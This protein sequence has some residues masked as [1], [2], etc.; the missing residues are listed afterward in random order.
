MGF[1]HSPSTELG[2]AKCSPD[3]AQMLALCY[4]VFLSDFDR[5]YTESVLKMRLDAQGKTLPAKKALLLPHGVDLRRQ[6]P[7]VQVQHLPRC[8]RVSLF[9]LMY[10]RLNSIDV[11]FRR[12]LSRS[13]R[14]T[15]AICKRLMPS[16]R[17]CKINCV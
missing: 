7:D 15:V 9:M 1:V 6:R 10:P 8:S 12:K 14:P 16:K 13:L 5:L 2:S 4:K 11:E 3:A 17:A